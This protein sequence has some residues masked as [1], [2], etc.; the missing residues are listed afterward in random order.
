MVLKRN[1]LRN[2]V[3]FNKATS[4][5]T[6]NINKSNINTSSI[7]P[8]VNNKKTTYTAGSGSGGW[9]VSDS[10]KSILD[11]LPSSFAEEEFV[12]PT[13]ETTDKVYDSW[14]NKRSTNAETADVK[15]YIADNSNPSGGF[16]EDL[17]KPYDDPT[18]PKYVLNE[19][20]GVT[21]FDDQQEKEQEKQQEDENKIT[22]FNIEDSNS[23]ENTMKRG[24]TGQGFQHVDTDEGII[25]A[26]TPEGAKL[27]E[28]KDY[29][30]PETRSSF[31]EL[32]SHVSVDKH[33]AALRKQEL[34]NFE[35]SIQKQYTT[36]LRESG[37]GDQRFGQAHFNEITDRINAS[38]ISHVKK[39]EMLY[40]YTNKIANYQKTAGGYGTATPWSFGTSSPK[41]LNKAEK[42]KQ[43][44]AS[45]EQLTEKEY[46]YLAVISGENKRAEYGEALGMGIAPDYS[47]MLDPGVTKKD[48]NKN[49]S[50]KPNWLGYEDL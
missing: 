34:A 45:G 21:Q 36:M 39:K 15:P 19:A 14:Y 23:L 37:P 50:N 48:I 25:F 27:F 7:N 12:G 6:S 11:P 4:I 30:E 31:Y 1:T 41:N 32:P 33:K 2:N 8:V 44:I 13:P 47:A 46:N 40:D 38:N 49:K 22:Y 42:L 35:N 17:F 16:L 10:I 43:K 18:H 3:T 26:K 28:I 24:A 5:N 20:D 9:A 29:I